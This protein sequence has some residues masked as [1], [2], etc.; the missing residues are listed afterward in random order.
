MDIRVFFSLSVLVLAGCVL[1]AEARP[2]LQSSLP[3][4][5]NGC[6]CD[7][8]TL[9]CGCCTYIK[10]DVP[11]LKINGT[12]CANLTW[13]LTDFGLSLTFA[14]DNK[15]IFNKTIPVNDPP[16]LCFPF[17]QIKSLEVCVRLRAV[18]Y[19]VKQFGACLEIAFEIVHVKQVVPLGC[20][21]N[22]QIDTLVPRDTFTTRDILKWVVDNNLQDVLS[23][24]IGSMGDILDGLQTEKVKANQETSFWKPVR[25]G[26]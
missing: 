2:S 14:W 24:L 3:G 26:N 17:P 22:D 1:M 11:Q 12:A 6:S 7:E 19:G 10:L 18:S 5:S 20:I 9:N 21:Y 23:G 4:Q 8:R 13:L 25:F 15:T 16:P